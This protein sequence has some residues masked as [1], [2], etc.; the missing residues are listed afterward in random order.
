MHRHLSIPGRR[1]FCIL[2][3]CPSRIPRQPCHRQARKGR[4]AACPARPFGRHTKRRRPP[5]SCR[6]FATGR[7][8]GLPRAFF[9]RRRQTRLPRPHRSPCA[10]VCL[11]RRALPGGTVQGQQASTQ[12]PRPSPTGTGT[13]GAG[14]IGAW[15]I[16]RTD[17]P[18]WRPGPRRRSCGCPPAPA[19][20]EFPP[21][22]QSARPSA[23]SSCRTRC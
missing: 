14:C 2:T 17:R 6:P 23:Q 10:V 1:I 4:L 8:S 18:N 13:T 7:T 21:C 15:R 22:P 16:T 19:R 9:F 5:A 3:S 20:P 11:P 12:P